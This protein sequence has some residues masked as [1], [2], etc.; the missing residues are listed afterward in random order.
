MCGMG[1]INL[2]NDNQILKI[3]TEMAMI[4]SFPK[5]SMYLPLTYWKK[6]VKKWNDSF[7]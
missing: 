6:D 4:T 5:I 2:F 7:Y 1:L 3:V